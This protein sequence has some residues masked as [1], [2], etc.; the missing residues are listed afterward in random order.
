MLVLL[1]TGGDAQELT[2]KA[3]L[4][5]GRWEMK[6]QIDRRREG[7]AFGLDMINRRSVE[8]RSVLLNPQSLYGR[9]D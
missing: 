2:H 6:V 4:S 5:C 9:R 3:S 8:L 1:S 7:G